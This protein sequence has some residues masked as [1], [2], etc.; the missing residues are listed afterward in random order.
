MRDPD[1]GL[2]SDDLA[3]WI[4]AQVDF[5]VLAAHV[6]PDL[7]HRVA[8]ITRVAGPGLRYEGTYDALVYRVQVRGDPGDPA[9]PGHADAERMA[10]DLDAVLLSAEMPT[11][12]TV[13]TLGFD[14][15][16]GAPTPDEDAGGSPVLTCNYVVLAASA[17]A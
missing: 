5:D 9:R 17:V 14:R 8:V 2:I 6:L 11:I 12:G 7:P 1:G 10:W 15:S 3:A 4:D 16:G 13:P